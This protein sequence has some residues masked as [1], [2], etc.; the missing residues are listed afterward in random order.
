MYAPMT[1]YS[2]AD[3]ILQA[4][5]ISLFFRIRLCFFGRLLLVPYSTGVNLK[6]DSLASSRC[7][8]E[9]IISLFEF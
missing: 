1:R 6:L 3:R 4:R 5:V 8:K 9:I 2:I 7:L